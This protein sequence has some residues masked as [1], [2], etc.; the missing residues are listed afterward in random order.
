MI[1]C[2][3]EEQLFSEYRQAVEDWKQATAF[4]EA[5]SKFSEAFYRALNKFEDCQRRALAAKQAY[6]VHVA[7]HGCDAETQ[8]RRLEVI[9]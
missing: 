3:E 9:P 5:Q 8:M 4:L 1:N 7:Q 2:G 6:D